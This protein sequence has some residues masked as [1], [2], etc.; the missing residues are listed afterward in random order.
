MNKKILSITVLLAIF[1]FGLLWQKTPLVYGQDASSSAEEISSETTKNLKDRI[2]RVVKEKEQE[3]KGVIEDLSKKKQGFI[4]EIER[5]SGETLSIKTVKNTR[6]IAIDETVTLLKN[7]KK[8]EL[9][10]IAVGDWLIVMGI[11]ED[12]N[13][14]AKRIIVSSE[15][16][17]P[18]SYIVALGSIS[19]ISKSSLIFQSRSQS[20]NQT[21]TL[22]KST[23]YQDMDGKKI[24]LSQLSE[25]SQVLV[26][27]YEED[28]PISSPNSV[29]SSTSGE[30]K[31]TKKIVTVIRTLSNIKID[32]E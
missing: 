4:G 23:S 2:Q 3:I 28:E 13:L 8:I 18:K 6:I 20:E 15:S 26:I 21:L 10:D 16:L 17:R 19:D 25:D 12:D 32:E 31:E 9:K 27:Y 1:E 5:V 29:T 24:D 7:N 11:L 22:S 14:V 30:N